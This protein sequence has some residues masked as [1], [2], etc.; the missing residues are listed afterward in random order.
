MEL[1]ASTFV[2]Q[3]LLGAGQATA[4]AQQGTYSKDHTED[5]RAAAFEASQLAMMMEKGTSAELA[6]LLSLQ[7]YDQQERST[8]GGSGLSVLDDYLS[9]VLYQ[10]EGKVEGFDFEAMS[11]AEEGNEPYF[12]IILEAL[13]M[14]AREAVLTISVYIE[15]SDAGTMDEAYWDAHIRLTEPD[16]TYLKVPFFILSSYF[17]TREGGADAITEAYGLEPQY[18]EDTEEMLD[19]GNRAARL[20]EYGM[21]I[22]DMENVDAIVATFTDVER[23][24]VNDGPDGVTKVQRFDAALVDKARALVAQNDPRH[25]EAQKFLDLSENARDTLEEVWLEAYTL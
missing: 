20:E 6:R 24:H 8:R 9:E 4:F 14:F 2:K 3:L 25:A 1:R 22:T 23:S 21:D 16:D 18:D 19:E 11:M 10:L 7:Y 13:R 5:E 12:G 15:H 17:E